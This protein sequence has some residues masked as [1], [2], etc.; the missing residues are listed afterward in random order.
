M[1]TLIGYFA[2]AGI[3]FFPVQETFA[4]ES[5]TLNVQSIT[6]SGGFVAGSQVPNQVRPIFGSESALTQEVTI[7]T[8][9]GL[10]GSVV[11]IHSL[12]EEESDDEGDG[13]RTHF[14]VG[15]EQSLP[16]GVKTSVSASII[17]IWNPSDDRRSQLA[18][19]FAYIQFPKLQGGLTP[20]AFS[21]NNILESVFD[22]E[23]ENTDRIT[24]GIGFQFGV[25]TATPI[26]AD[27][28]V[29]GY[30]DDDDDFRRFIRATG[31]IDS[32]FKYGDRDVGVAVEGG[33]D[34]ELDPIDDDDDRYRFITSAKL[35]I[36]I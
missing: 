18:G 8:P 2:L 23:Q 11:N 16:L 27:V 30:M 12:D 3:F 36:K 21:G 14:S 31:R 32:S 5:T 7:T 25:N 34:K 10:F 15:F 1:R 13:N 9:V 33:F 4:E 35:S 29:F 20:Y 28:S 19:S 26:L 22:V 17:K 6:V 24:S